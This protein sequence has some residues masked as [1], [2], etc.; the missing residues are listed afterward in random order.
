MPKIKIEEQTTMAQFIYF[1]KGL[2]S[3]V[4]SSGE[5]VVTPEFVKRSAKNY[6]FEVEKNILQKKCIDCGVY[7]DVYELRGTEWVDIHDEHILH[8]HSI[9]SGFKTRCTKCDKVNFKQKYLGDEQYNNDVLPEPNKDIIKN[10]ELKE[11]NQPQNIIYSI[12][13]DDIIIEFNLLTLS[14]NY[15]EKPKISISRSKA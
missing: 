4:N 8:F 15:Q 2:Y 11:E 1:K 3:L 10:V 12:S 5:T 13:L 6:R 14:K 7:H 9:S